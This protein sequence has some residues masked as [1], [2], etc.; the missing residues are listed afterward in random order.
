MLTMFVLD[1]CRVSEFVK[2]L[3]NDGVLHWMASENEGDLFLTSLTLGE[4]IKGIERLPLGKRRNELADWCETQLRRRFQN[5]ILNF[6]ENAG[7]TWGRLCARMEKL[8]YRMPAVDSQIAAVC[9]FYG[10]TLVTR[11]VADFKDSGIA[12]LNPWT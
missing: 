3:P 8:G 5:R 6:D 12:I 2:K 4:V 11:N 10:A 9:S 7:M 1:T